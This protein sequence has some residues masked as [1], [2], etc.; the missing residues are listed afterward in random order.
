MTAVRA[1]LAEL[2]RRQPLLARSGWA[3]LALLAVCLV[4]MALDPRLIR[5]VSVWTKPAKFAASFVVWF[6]TLA[7]AWGVLAP[8]LR[9]GGVARAVLWTTLGAGW[10][11]LGWIT[12]RG[13][14]GLP[15]HFATDPVAQA[16]Y[17]LMGIGAVALVVAATVLGVLVLARPAP[18]QERAWVFAVGWGL[19]LA[20]ALGLLTGATISGHDGPY[21]GATP[22][23][24]SAFP[25]FLWSREGGDLRV[26]HFIGIHA[27]QALP[28]LALLGASVPVIALGAAAWTA[29]TLAALA[30]ALAGLPLSP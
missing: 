4:A 24:G 14:L 29:A 9:P 18:G 15:S 17:T 30:A 27:M 22:L 12:A 11:E 8:A 6:W 21:V 5:G 13:A 3:A 23:D 1:I 20:G 25:P 19:V 16:M 26:A 10:F 28:A 7:W 2:D